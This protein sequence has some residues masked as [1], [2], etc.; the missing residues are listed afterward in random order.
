[1]AANRRQ[2]VQTPLGVL[3]GRDCIY[4]D[5]AAFENGTSELVLRGAINGELVGAGPAGDFAY[6]LRF[7]GVLAVR[8]V[9]LD[10]WEGNALSSFDEVL[11]SLWAA[12]LGGKVSAAHRHLCIAT[13]DDVF[14]VIC[15][16][17]TLQLRACEAPERGTST[18]HRS[19]P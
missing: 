19:R 11:G 12:E 5:A 16:A 7:T 10:S 2:P 3:R 4:L 1:M 9:E 6:V 13:Y 17:F 8:M 18:P 14:D 15:S